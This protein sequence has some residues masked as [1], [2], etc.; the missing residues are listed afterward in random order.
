M[1]ISLRLIV[2]LILGVTLLS[3][4]FAIFQQRAEK[5]GL[6]DDLA[7]RAQILAESLGANVEPCLAR[8]RAA[9]CR[10]SSS[11]SEKANASPELRC[12]TNWATCLP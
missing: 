12:L 10:K 9:I 7:K 3:A 6:R 2:S 5:R 8:V 4:A 1:R 11:S